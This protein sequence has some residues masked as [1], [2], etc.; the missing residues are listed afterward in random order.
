MSTLD[1]V[2]S[3]AV[4]S[5]VQ[6]AEFLTENLHGRLTDATQS[7]LSREALD[8]LQTLRF[9]R[10]LVMGEDPAARTRP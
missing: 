9:Q 10:R 4:P 3:D 7:P 1:H 5:L 6:K 2:D 8:D